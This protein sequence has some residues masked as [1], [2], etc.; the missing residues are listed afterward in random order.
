MHIDAAADDGGGDGGAAMV[1]GWS[2]A[3]WFVSDEQADEG[4]AWDVRGLVVVGRRDGAGGTAETVS[5]H[6]GLEEWS[7][8]G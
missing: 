3:V 6:M 7:G 2:G 4:F 1:V 8:K 5:R